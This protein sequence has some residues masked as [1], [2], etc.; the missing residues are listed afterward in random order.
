MSAPVTAQK[1]LDYWF[2][3]ELSRVEPSMDWAGLGGPSLSGIIKASEA[4]KMDGLWQEENE[5]DTLAKIILFD[6]FPRNIFR[7]NKDAFACDHLALA[8]A[9]TLLPDKWKRLPFERQLFALMPLQHSEDAAVH[10]ESVRYFEE[11]RAMA[12]TPELAKSCDVE[13]Q[14]VKSHK[15][16]IAKFGRFP[17]RNAALGRDSTPEE[18]E[19]LKTS[20]TFGQ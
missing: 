2:K 13:V 19:Y 5:S 15:E 12:P 4:G 1:V 3:N 18:L 8:T 11:R 10:E 17:H 20:D 6:Q 7:K 16:M 9:R 14:Y